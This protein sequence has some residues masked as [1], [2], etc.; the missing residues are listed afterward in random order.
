MPAGAQTEIVQGRLHTHL[1]TI[2]SHPH[3][4]ISFDPCWN[5]A[6]PVSETSPRIFYILTRKN[7]S[8]TK[9]II[10]ALKPFPSMAYN[11]TE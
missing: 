3:I 1:K 4:E 6:K 9:V 8:T 10:I 5:Q 2:A 11:P 7:Q